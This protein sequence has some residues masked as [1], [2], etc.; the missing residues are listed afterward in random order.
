MMQCEVVYSAMRTGNKVQP[1]EKH[2]FKAK[3]EADAKRQATEWG[4]IPDF[5][6]ARWKRQGNGKEAGKFI[7]SIYEYDLELVLTLRCC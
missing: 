2:K 7:K 3:N 6:N 4:E 5:K 1:D